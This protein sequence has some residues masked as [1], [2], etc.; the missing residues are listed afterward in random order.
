MAENNLFETRPPRGN[1]TIYW[2]WAVLLAFFVLASFWFTNKTDIG[3]GEPNQ[4]REDLNSNYIRE[5]IN[6]SFFLSTFTK[7]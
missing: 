5:I 4:V 3:K 7:L 1:S 6:K 2:T